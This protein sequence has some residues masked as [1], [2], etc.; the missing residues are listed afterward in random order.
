V[1][2]R[3]D[4]AWWSG[5]DLTVRELIAREGVR[6]RWYRR[7]LRSWWVAAASHGITSWSRRA[8]PVGRMWP[9]PRVVNHPT[10]RRGDC[11]GL[12]G[13]EARI[14]SCQRGDLRGDQVPKT[15]GLAVERALN[16]GCQ[17]ADA[18]G[19]ARRHARW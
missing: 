15:A 16:C 8:K 6:F 19:Q 17:V 12:R 13:G 10:M 9:G 5:R 2:L 3:V 18:G 14:R 7:G 1:V 11:A 4:D